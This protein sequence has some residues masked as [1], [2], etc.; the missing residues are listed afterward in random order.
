MLKDLAPKPDSGRVAKAR[1]LRR[2]MSLPEGLLWRELRKR[3]SGL[4]FRRQHP[5]GAYVL[6]FYCSDAR[7]AVEIDGLS[8]DFGN[9]PERDAMRDGWFVAAGIVTLRVSAGE[10]LRDFEAVLIHIVSEARARL[11]L[12]H[13]AA[14]GGPPPRDE[15][16]EE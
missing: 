12:H 8:H 6:D 16:G 5:S 10:V 15:L 1:R 13:P 11:P 7:L 9:R 4:K 14:P 3:P 2:E